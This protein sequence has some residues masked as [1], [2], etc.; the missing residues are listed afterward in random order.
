MDIDMIKK[1]AADFL[2]K[3]ASNFVTTEEAIKPAYAGMRI[4]EEAVIKI[5]DAG[6]PLFTENGR[7][8]PRDWLPGAKSVISIA[9]TLSQEIKDAN[10]V[11]LTR[12][13]N[14]WLHGATEGF[15]TARV[16]LN[17]VCAMLREEGFE[18][19]SPEINADE[20][21]SER[22]TGYVCGQGTYGMSGGL[23]TEKG[24]AVILGSIVTDCPLPVTPRKYQG[25]YDY[26][27]RCGKCS[28]N[29]PAGAI[30][31]EKGPEAAYYPET[32]GAYIEKLKK[33]V[34]KGGSG[35]ILFGCG[36]CKVAVP[37][38]SRIPGK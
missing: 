4:L 11:N 6:D 9:L 8:P 36:K 31:T 27:D 32:C 35:R 30:D 29:C 13:A 38:A 18:A 5:G 21:W 22:Y 28:R 20:K 15:D 37:C 14:E 12:P 17:K 33:S 3:D 10:T 26:C 2:K 34:P 7:K 19:V 16:F 1:A 23:I 25:L 24:S